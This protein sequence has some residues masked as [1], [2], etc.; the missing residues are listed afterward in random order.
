MI[1][2]AFLNIL[3]LVYEIQ[4]L[5]IYFIKIYKMKNVFLVFF[6][7]IFVGS[8]AQVYDTYGRSQSTREWQ[9]TVRHY[10]SMKPSSPYQPQ[11]TTQQVTSQDLANTFNTIENLFGLKKRKKTPQEIQQEAAASKKAEE[12]R[13]AERRMAWNNNEKY[14]S[15]LIVERK[16][17]KHWT[18]YSQIVQAATEAGLPQ[19]WNGRV[20]GY[21]ASEFDNLCNFSTS[22]LHKYFP[23]KDHPISFTFNDLSTKQKATGEYRSYRQLTD[24]IKAFINDGKNNFSNV[25]D[26]ADKPIEPV[27]SSD[28]NY[29]LKY[30]WL[31]FNAFQYGKFSFGKYPY[32]G[33]SS[34]G[35]TEDEYQEIITYQINDFLATGLYSFEKKKDN[36]GTNFILKL[37]KEYT[38]EPMVDYEFYMLIDTRSGVPKLQMFLYK[39]EVE[40]KQEENKATI[41]ESLQLKPGNKKQNETGNNNTILSG[42]QLDETKTTVTKAVIINAGRVFA[43]IVNTNCL[44]WSWATAA[45]KKLS[46]KTGWGN[47]KPKNGDEGIIVFTAMH[48]SKKINISIL[49][50]GDYYIPIAEEGLLKKL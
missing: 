20:F 27:V 28:E 13:I 3:I 34:W 30:Y 32:I 6:V 19:I 25:T 43:N 39:S 11:G 16:I 8:K 38:P 4:L 37:K 22:T 26:R 47:Y 31:D 18:Y 12:Q 23:D 48:C 14:L 40:I 46:G 21:N 24:L 36:Y 44:D 41:F 42:L 2:A 15:Q 9:E 45:Q 33:F 7:L 5:L 50:V 1:L 49:K 10:E 29:R 35:L 17:R